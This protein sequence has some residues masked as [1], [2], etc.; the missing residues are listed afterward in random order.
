MKRRCMLRHWFAQAVILLTVCDAA[1]ADKPT[2]TRFDQSLL[3]AYGDPL[4]PHALVRLG[5]Q[6]FHPESFVTA[7]A[8]SPDGRLLASTAAGQATAISL[9]EVPSGHLIRRLTMPAEGKIWPS[10]NALAFCPDGQR[11]LTGDGLGRLH[12]WNVANGGE[13]YSIAAH[14]ASRGF[15][16]VSA[17]AFSDD[18]AWFAS[19]GADGVARVWNT[20]T[21]R[22]LLSFDVLGPQPPVPIPEGIDFP[23]PR[24]AGMPPGALAAL[25]FSPDGRFLSVGMVQRPFASKAGKIR[26]WDLEANQPVRSLDTSCGELMSLAYTPDGRQLI[27]GGNVMMPRRSSAS[28]IVG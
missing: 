10:T 24:R 6:R 1:L 16:G 5:T 12:L 8:F 11:L 7:T 3:D 20:D 14:D 26:I 13:I 21:G 18:G 4:P 25:A 19:G 15:D 23:V 9:W 27:S 2:S 28:R 17:V 22:E